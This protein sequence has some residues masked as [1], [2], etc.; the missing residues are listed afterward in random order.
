M[1]TK[2]RLGHSKR[3]ELQNALEK[4]IGKRDE[5]ESGGEQQKN[6]S[7]VGDKE[8]AIKTKNFR[9]EKGIS[10]QLKEGEEKLTSTER[11]LAKLCQTREV[12]NAKWSQSR[13]G[14]DLRT[15]IFWE[16]LLN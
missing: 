14:G 10:Q 3:A 6:V 4:G 5:T 15:V 11:V 9:A 7:F 12:R 1:V 2:G 13:S 16:E 8:V